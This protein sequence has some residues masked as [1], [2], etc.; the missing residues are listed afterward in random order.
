MTWALNTA[1]KH[2]GLTN[3]VV[4]S[5]ADWLDILLEDGRSFRFRPGQLINEDAEESARE[6]VL[7]RLITIGIKQAEHPSSTETP[8]SDGDSSP[9]A[10]SPE[11]TPKSDPTPAAQS[12]SAPVSD[13]MAAFLPENA[14]GRDKDAPADSDSE[15]AAQPTT[16]DVPDGNPENLEVPDDAKVVPIIRSA[17]YYLASHNNGDSI[18]YL[19]LTEFVAVGIA[20]DLDDSIAPIYYSQLGGDMREIGEIMAEGV[21]NLRELSASTSQTQ[22][23]EMGVAQVAGAQVMAFMRPTNYELSWFAD[24]DMVQQIAE[25][26]SKERPDDI[27]LF[28]PASRTKLFVVFADDKRLVNFFKLLYDQRDDADAV[29]PLPHTVAADGWREWVPFPGDELA[30]TLGALRNHF[31]EKIYADQVNHMSTWGD[32]GSLKPFTARK[33]KT[34]DHVSSTTW[35]ASDKSGSIPK[36]DFITFTRQASPHEWETEPAVSITIRTHVALEVWPEG[37]KVDEDAWPPRYEVSGFP[38]EEKLIELRDAAGR[39]F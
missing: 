11:T 12:P 13:P 37:M 14:P 17:N 38:S 34:G 19:P 35:D 27:P 9:S 8:D 32:F 1:T 30:N 20:H 15:P 31:R 33:L 28:V 22:S 26:I 23:L 3:A 24:L 4:N 25:Q 7:N 21:M 5:N 6:D 29:Y 39:T 16:A 18:V 2:P 10:P 36:T